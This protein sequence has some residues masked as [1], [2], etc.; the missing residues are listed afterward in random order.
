MSYRKARSAWAP[1][2]V[3]QATAGLGMTGFGQTEEVA[4]VTERTIWPQVIA[5][6]SV[7]VIVL[8]IVLAMGKQTIGRAY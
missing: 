7:G 8:G 5:A 6:G 1:P 4:E 2:R 3:V